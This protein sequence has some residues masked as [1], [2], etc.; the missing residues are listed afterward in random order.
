MYLGFTR[1]EPEEGEA[2]G[3]ADGRNGRVAGDG[4][5]RA[6]EGVAR[7][8]VDEACHE[9]VGAVEGDVEGLAEERVVRLALEGG[10][11]TAEIPTLVRVRCTR[12]A[13]ATEG[14]LSSIRRGRCHH[15]FGGFDQ[16]THVSVTVKDTG[17]HRD[18]VHTSL[19]SC[20]L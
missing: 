2:K 8:A 1:Q 13:T 5:Q 10:G 12:Q 6:V 16:V 19:S 14:G 4:T 15:R 18:H 11:A 7:A 20:R 17:R 9:E 3:A